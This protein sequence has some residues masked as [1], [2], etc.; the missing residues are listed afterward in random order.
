MLRS[1]RARSA[2]PRDNDSLT[3]PRGN[4]LDRQTWPGSRLPGHV[5]ESQRTNPLK[6]TSK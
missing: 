4:G 5:S 1:S 6:G 3:A 2:V